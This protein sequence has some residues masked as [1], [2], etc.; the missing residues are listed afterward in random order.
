MGHRSNFSLI[1][2]ISI[3]SHSNPL[4]GRLF[5]PT[6]FILIVHASLWTFYIANL[7]ADTISFYSPILSNHK[8][9][10]KYLG[11][12]SILF[13]SNTYTTFLS[14]ILFGKK[15]VQ[16]FKLKRVGGAPKGYQFAPLMI[17]G[18]IFATNHYFLPQ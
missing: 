8:H 2:E 3:G 7:V 1:G 14:E 15:I 16:K 10:Y 12:P 11:A 9:R 5:G 6:K 13:S 17:L 4:S 18:I